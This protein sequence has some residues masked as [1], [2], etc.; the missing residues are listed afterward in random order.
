MTQRIVQIIPTM[1]RGG[2][3]KQLCLLAEHLPRDQFDVHVVLLTHDGPRSQSLRD[4]DIPVTVIGK[5]FKADPSALFRLRREL[6]RL[7][8]DAVHTWLFAA[9]SFGRA[10]ARWAGVRKIFASER[11]VDPWKTSAHLMI[12]RTL[13]KRTNAITTNSTG[14]RDFYVGHGIDRDLFRIIPNG[15]PPRKTS[16]IDRDEAFSRLKV[17]SD[18]KL[19]LAV[20]R[21]WP[22]K[23]YRDLIW[24][25]ELTGTVREDTTL[26]IIGDGPQSG[27]L[28][29]HRD[30]VTT[31]QRVRFA[32]QRDDVSDLLPHADAFWIGSEYEGQSNSVIEAMQAGVPVIASD[33]PG[34][35]DLVVSGQTGMLVKLGDTADFARQT[36]ELFNEKATADQ[37]GDAAKQRIA[38]E[39]TVEK[40]V[41]SHADLYEN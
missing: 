29:R 39:F 7:K 27:E 6:M 33:I 1:D 18:R 37:L 41:Q 26:V 38:T 28:L 11:C 9:N 22:Q 8:P 3:E 30:A 31:P 25:A 5:R 40:M 34:N 4:A 12:D 35:R 10:A 2:A 20:G 19:I 15:I 16:S 13:A 23:R 32:G 17:E 21:L 36:I 24:A 14:V